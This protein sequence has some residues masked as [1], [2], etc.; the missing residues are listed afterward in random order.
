[1]KIYFVT[2]NTGKYQE[3]K[4]ALQTVEV[5]QL[6]RTYPEIQADSLHEVARYGITFLA[7]QMDDVFMIEDSGLFPQALKG[8][9]GVYSAYVFK[10]I[11]NKGILKVME[12]VNQ[13]T[14]IFQ[15][16]IGLY[17]GET[18][19]FEGSCRGKIADTVRGTHG[20]GYDP[21]FIPHGSEKTF[22][23]MTR[24]EK[25]RYSHRGHAVRKLIEY[26]SQS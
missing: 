2:T 12:G 10:S 15:S 26:L 7:A 25:N 17:D 8:F 5:K 16:V 11:G 6:D 21:I 23:E 22:G 3:V 4:D 18:R 1:M 14:A 9:P 20:F 24:K 19:L 13:R